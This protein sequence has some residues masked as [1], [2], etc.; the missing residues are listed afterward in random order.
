MKSMA[1][2][3]TCLVQLLWQLTL[4]KDFTQTFYWQIGIVRINRFKLAD[5]PVTLYNSG[6][7]GGQTLLSDKN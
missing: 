3:T 7:V 2:L 6:V 4:L 5:N 1:T